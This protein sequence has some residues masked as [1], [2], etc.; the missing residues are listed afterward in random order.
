MNEVLAEFLTEAEEMLRNYRRALAEAKT[1]NSELQKTLHQAYRAIHTVHGGSGF[2]A[3]SSLER[4]GRFAEGLLW[5]L[6]EEE[7][8][9]SQAE[10]VLLQRV[11]AACTEIL[12]RLR[13]EGQEGPSPEILK[14]LDLKG[15][16]DQQTGRDRNE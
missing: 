3:L 13:R 2:L 9:P 1:G 4:L 6:E 11:D 7:R 16:K 14:E 5:K 8:P 15:G 12:R 10:R